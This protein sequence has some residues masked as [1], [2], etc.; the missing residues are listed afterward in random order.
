MDEPSLR[1]AFRSHRLAA[2]AAYVLL[3]REIIKV[4]AAIVIA[5]IDEDIER[6]AK[7]ETEVRGLKIQF[8]EAEAALPPKVKRMLEE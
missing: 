7:L 1:H 8:E 5:L 3:L 2:L 6:V 4:N